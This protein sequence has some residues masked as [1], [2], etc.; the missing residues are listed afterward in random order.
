MR[1]G[2]T[3]CVN[4][5]SRQSREPEI[6][7][8]FAANPRIHVR[9]TPPP[10]SWMNLVEVWF[11]IIERQAIHRGIFRSVRGPNAKIRAFIDGWNNHSHPFV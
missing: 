10:G 11:G 1:C 6:R 8:W 5:G 2:S 3:S 4:G 7:D 9:F